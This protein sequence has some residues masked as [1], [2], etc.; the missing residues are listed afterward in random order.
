MLLAM[1]TRDAIGAFL[2]VSIWLMSFSTVH[3]KTF[4]NDRIAR[5]DVS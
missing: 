3:I 5:C 2:S 1:K 4:E